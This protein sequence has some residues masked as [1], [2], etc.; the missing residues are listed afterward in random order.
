VLADLKGVFPALNTNAYIVL[1]DANYPGVSDAVADFVS[2]SGIT[3]CGKIGR[4]RNESQKNQTYRGKPVIWGGLHLL[5][6]GNPIRKT[7]FFY[8]YFSKQR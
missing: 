8:S 5:Y 2:T 6:H 1:H 7:S 4:D 3:D